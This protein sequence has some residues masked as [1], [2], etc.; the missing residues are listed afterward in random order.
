MKKKLFSFLALVAL[1]M[2][3]VACEFWSDDEI[4]NVSPDR[5]TYSRA[6]RY[7]DILKRDLQDI[8]D[9]TI[10]NPAYQGWRYAEIVEYY[11]QEAEAL[12]RDLTVFRKELSRLSTREFDDRRYRIAEELHEYRMDV[13]DFELD[14][15]RDVSRK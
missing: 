5:L 13:E 15:R 8:E 9:R 12:Q 10:Y 11:T 4:L 3:A 1:S 7:I 14:F 6:V 2:L